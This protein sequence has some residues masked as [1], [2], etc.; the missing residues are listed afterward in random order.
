LFFCDISQVFTAD[1]GCDL[2]FFNPR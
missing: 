1:S 2:A